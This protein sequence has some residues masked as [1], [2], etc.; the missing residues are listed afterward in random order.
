MY[1]ADTVCSEYRK[2]LV[3]FVPTSRFIS[4]V[5]RVS[6]RTNS[7][8]VKALDAAST[9]VRIRMAATPVDKSG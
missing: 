2:E 7:G 6:F 5:A 9:M 1:G 4:S 8:I 3:K